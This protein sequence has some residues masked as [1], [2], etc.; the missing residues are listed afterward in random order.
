M[1]A[2]RCAACNA[3]LPCHAQVCHSGS[4]TRVHCRLC[5]LQRSGSAQTGAVVCC[6]CL[7]SARRGSQDP[8]PRASGSPRGERTILPWANARIPCRTGYDAYHA[9]WDTVGYI[10]Q[11][12]PR[13]SRYSRS[14]QGT[15]VLYSRCSRRY[16]MKAVRCILY[17]HSTLYGVLEWCAGTYRS[18]SAPSTALASRVAAPSPVGARRAPV[19]TAQSRSSRAAQSVPARTWARRSRCGRGRGFDFARACTAA[20]AY[21]PPKLSPPTTRSAGALSMISVMRRTYLPR[22]KW[23]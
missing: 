15:K 17:H 7:W 1:A 16:N 3:H 19:S 5:N 21:V 4:M 10:E 14:Q 20:S 2:A 18:R 9:V 23:T 13:Y 12:Y 22:T 11:R 8:S 6:A